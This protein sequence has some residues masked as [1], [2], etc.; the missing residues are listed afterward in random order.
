[1]AEYYFGIMQTAPEKGK[2]FTLI[3]PESFSAIIEIIW[4]NP[5]LSVIY[6]MDLII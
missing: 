5:D 3:P 6:N 1:M 4:H 2:R